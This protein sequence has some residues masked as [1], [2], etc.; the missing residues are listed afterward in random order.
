MTGGREK[1]NHRGHEDTETTD[2]SQSARRPVSGEWPHGVRT[3]LS[4]KTQS[5][6]DRIRSVEDSRHR[7]APVV[8]GW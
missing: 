7:E 3:R 5:V 4:T 1:R 6:T 2:Q 8:R